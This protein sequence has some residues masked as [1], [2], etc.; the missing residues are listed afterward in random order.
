M[1]RRWR[2]SQ[3]VDNL[4]RTWFEDGA[5]K[6][7][8][9]DMSISDMLTFQPSRRRPPR[10]YGPYTKAAIKIHPQQ[11]TDLCPQTAWLNCRSKA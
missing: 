9:N 11:I 10:E 2:G 5:K 6:W 3:W 1:I 8:R 4:G 7:W